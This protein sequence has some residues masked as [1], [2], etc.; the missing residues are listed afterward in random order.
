MK[1]SDECSADGS[2]V[3]LALGPDIEKPATERNA[4]TD[5]RD[6]QRQRP[7]ETLLK[8]SAAKE[9]TVQYAVEHQECGVAGNL[10]QG[11]AN[12]RSQQDECQ[13]PQ[14]CI[15]PAGHAAAPTIACPAVARS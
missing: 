9:R 2:H 6:E 4:H 15:K 12:D 8:R 11:A 10:E 14:N 13:R 7:S 1:V 3:E 5:C